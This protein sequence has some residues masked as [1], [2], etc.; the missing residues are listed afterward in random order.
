MDDQN[1]P[2]PLGDSEQHAVELMEAAAYSRL[3]EG[4]LWRLE[5]AQAFRRLAE[6]AKKS[7]TDAKN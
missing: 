1:T 7:E 6:L 5:W 3:G 4:R 2:K